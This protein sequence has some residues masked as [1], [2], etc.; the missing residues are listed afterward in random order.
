MSLALI[1][2]CLAFVA[3]EPLSAEKTAVIS[4]EQEKAQAEVDAKYGNKKPTE[5]SADERRQQAKDRAA[6][7]QQVLDKNGVSAKEWARESLRKDREQFAQQKELKK[8]LI[9]KEKAA[10]EAIKKAQAQLKEV[11]VQK[12]FSD[13]NPVTLEEKENEDGKV[14]VE[15]GLPGDLSQDEEAAREQDRLE[16]GGSAGASDDA[17]KAA[18]KTRGG[19]RRR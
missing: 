14:A 8:Q 19:G 3:D 13:E 17:P 15:K 2:L 5:L 10:A 7:E 11:Q 18:P 9:E 16:N 6:A 1:A 12:G 4:R